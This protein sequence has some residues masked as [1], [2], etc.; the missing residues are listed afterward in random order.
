MEGGSG[1]E[2]EEGRKDAKGE[3]VTAASKFLATRTALLIL[4]GGV[5]RVSRALP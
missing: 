1:E 3:C 5:C 4:R 2:A